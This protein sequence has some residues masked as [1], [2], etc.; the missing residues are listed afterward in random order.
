MWE[1]APSHMDID[2]GICPN[3]TS[4][5]NRLEKALSTKSM[6]DFD[7]YLTCKYMGYKTNF[8]YYDGISRYKNLKINLL[9]PCLY[10]KKNLPKVNIPLLC[11]NSRDDP[12]IQYHIFTYKPSNLFGKSP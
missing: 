9:S 11:M 7:N 10:S 6:I 2:L 8:E 5:T 12:I 4:L 1:N 3:T